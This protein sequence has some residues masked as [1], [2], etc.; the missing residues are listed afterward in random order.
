M[1]GLDGFATCKLLKADPQHC[2]IPVIFMTAIADVNSKIKGFEHGAVDYITKPFQEQEVLARVKTHLQLRCL[3]QHLEQQVANRTADLRSAK[4]AAEAANHAKSAFLATI[5][6]ELRTPLNAILGMAEG[7][8]E[9]IFGDIS[10]PQRISIQTIERSG[11]HLLNLINDLIDLAK[12]EA[13]MLELKCQPTPIIRLCEF[14][15]AAI[16]S[17]ANKKAIQLELNISTDLPDLMI[18]ECRIQQVL[19]E[20]LNNAI[21]FTP[22]GGRVKLDVSL[23]ADNSTI[24]AGT[25]NTK[26]IR[27]ATIDTGIG[28]APENIPKLFQ[29]FSQIDNALNRRYQGIGIGLALVKRIVE[30]HGG[31]VGLT[32]QLGVGSCFSIDLPASTQPVIG[33]DSFIPAVE[34]SNPT[35]VKILLVED[36]QDNIETM[37]AYLESRGYH[38]LVANNGQEAI[39]LLEGCAND[40]AQGH[41]PDI[42]LMDIQMPIMNGL[43]ATRRL[44]QMPEFAAL[45]ILALTAFAMPEDCQKCLDAGANQYLTKPVK[46]GQLVATIEILLN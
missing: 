41:L 26:Y 17:P 10:Q 3:T 7:L 40:L 37:T 42:I 19:T 31:N 20:L 2:D 5:S 8:Q 30:W 38:L 45:P 32:S 43:E 15:L 11:Q 24:A 27:I 22:A 28:I 21:K 44:R 25:E 1:L 33:P 13:G 39:S 14:S 23:L 18:D 35:P 29:N 6:H 12:I 9:E 34:I 16:R 46:L 36:D 4:E